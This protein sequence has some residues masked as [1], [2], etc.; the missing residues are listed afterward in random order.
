MHFP[1]L[2][3]AS[4]YD[5]VSATRTRLFSLLSPVYPPEPTAEPGIQW[6]LNR[7]DGLNERLPL[8]TSARQTWACTRVPW[9]NCEATDSD[10]GGLR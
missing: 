4:L 2:L 8:Q 3:S 10:P 7:N 6:V 1:H 9:G 5:N